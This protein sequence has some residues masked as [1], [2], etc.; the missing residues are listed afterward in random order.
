MGEEFV[1][2]AFTILVAQWEPKQYKVTFKPGDGTGEMADGVATY[3]RAY[4]LPDCTFKAPADGYVFKA[5]LLN[6]REVPEG[7][8]LLAESDT[9]VTALWEKLLYTITFEG[10]GAAGS[11]AAVQ[12]EPGAEYT[13]PSPEGFDEG[14]VL[15]FDGWKVKGTQTIYR[16]GKKITVDGNMTLV[17]QW[18]GRK[19]SLSYQDANGNEVHKVEK[20]Y[21]Q[22]HTVL[23][24]AEAAELGLTAPAGYQF[25]GWQ[26]YNNEGGKLKDVTATAGQPLTLYSEWWIRPVWEKIIYTI[27]F[28]SNGATGTMNAVTVGENDSYKVPANAFTAPK[29]HHFEGW[30]L[31]GTMMEAG[32]T[33]TVS[34]NITLKANWAKNIY[35]VKTLDS[36]DASSAVSEDKEYG[37]KITLPACSY[38]ATSE[39]HSF[40]YWK[41][42]DEQGVRKMKAGDSVTVE[43]DTV[44]SAIWDFD[45]SVKTRVEQV[46]DIANLPPQEKKELEQQMLQE[47]PPKL[48]TIEAVVEELADQA[49]DEGFV[50]EQTEVHEVKLMFKPAYSDEWIEATEENFPTAGIEVR[51]PLPEGTNAAD[52][53]FL[54]IHMFTTKSDRLGTEPGKTETIVPVIENGELVFTLNGL[55]PVSVAWKERPVE[56]KLEAA[57]LPKTGD[58]SCLMAWITLLGASGA[59]FAVIGR[60]KR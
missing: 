9:E 11:I 56:G 38:T 53:E 30:T 24:A 32:K 23:T 29:G 46:D 28:D 15:Q 10:N 50:A 35:T 58:A 18:K 2:E 19:V 3:G 51:M 33:I 21:G 26:L 25:A 14:E 7:T 49:Q 12:V 5:W 45:D 48:Q 16:Q 34:G 4:N 22:S 47:M 40:A 44:I 6:G 31:D 1:T 36:N 54:V 60:R 37:T 17:A 20:E 41:V 39:Y 43:S 52:F 42:E 57:Q 27:T 59:G 13:L 55:S 8:S